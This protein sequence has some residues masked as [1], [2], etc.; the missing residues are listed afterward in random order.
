MT[1]SLQLPLGEPVNVVAAPHSGG[2]EATSAPPAPTQVALPKVGLVLLVGISGSGKST[3]AAQHFKPTQVISSDFCRALV[4]D[5]ES[6]QAATPDAFAVLNYIVGTR[7]KRGLLTVV[8]A[9]NV[10]KS[11]RAELVKL[12]KDHDVLVDAIV[13][14]VPPNLA[15][16]RGRNRAVIA[17]QYEDLKRSLSQL[18]KEGFRRVHVLSAGEIANAQ[19]SYQKSWN[20]LTE[21][22]GPFDIIGDVHGCLTELVELLS[23][24]GY[25]IELSDNSPVNARHPEGR[26]AIFVGDLVDRG[27]DTP[28]VL[29]LVMGMVQAGNALC[30]AGNH[31]AKLVRALK[32]A[33]VQKTHGIEQSLAQFENETPEFRKQAL[34]FMDK[35]IAYYVL[36]DGQLIVAHAGLKEAYHGRSSN[37]VRAFALYG[38]TTG[39]SDEYGLPVRLPWAQEYRG[40][41]LVVYGHTPTLDPEW[42]N[43]TICVD[44]GCVFGGKLTAMRYPERQLVSV[45]AQA[46]Y[47]QPA[48]PLTPQ[49]SERI[50]SVLQITDVAGTRWLETQLA[51]RV[52]VPEENAVAA[53]EVMS[54][55]AV[56]PRWLIYLPPT[57]SPAP[58]VS[59]KDLD[60]AGFL[61]WPEQ[62]FNEYAAAGVQEVVC[63][64]KHMGSRAVAVIARDAQ[65]AERRFGI[66]PDG[67]GQCALGAVYTRTGRA[68]FP[69]ELG[70]AL[71]RR[72]HTAIEPLFAALNTDWLALDC[73]L[74]P[75][76]AKAL[77]L[78]KEQYAAVGAAAN[79]VFPPATALLTQAAARGLDV[80]DLAGRVQHRAAD[81]AAYRDAYAAYVRPTDGLDG[82]TLA[83]FQILAGEGEVYALTR[84]HRWH[85]QQIALLNDPFIM[86][87]RHMFVDLTDDAQRAAGTSWWLDLTAYGGEGM[88][89]KPVLPLP[90]LT[91][92]STKHQI[93]P[94]L[95][96]RG[97]EYLRIIY[98]PDY[99]DNLA[100]LRNR[101]LGRKK[102]LAWR[103]FGLGME[104][105]TKFVA[106]DPLWQIHQLVF[107]I[108]ALE[109]EA[110]DPRL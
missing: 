77:G 51:G 43:N 11:A 24:L 4:S 8:D 78:I 31:E 39:E 36:D 93:Q 35:L 104:S 10:Q 37:R 28:G 94:G 26:T 88:V 90:Q 20:D 42:I 29:R 56:D 52:K 72:V 82:I 76:S 64:E 98:G 22:N 23:K 100:N 41:A 101:Q 67:T 84:S 58:A 14:D 74:L 47:Y 75:W 16:A 99:L 49:V 25:V 59:G 91:S 18:R 46:Q 1:D 38:D 80:A 12:A 69:G 89:V 17:R 107:A 96:V 50:P 30:V 66:V 103:E 32:G 40:K 95:K 71:V 73:E 85:L 3:F 15:I 61:E 62:A 65:A 48:K 57:M 44:T 92:N 110:I 109:S 87:T 19:I 68:F 34:D 86:Q 54:R 83:P 53:L 6:D 105:L 5:D 63:E 2:F 9:T 81:A 97:R 60:T 102:N 27:P 13:L 45:A 55:F 7:L 108:L 70:E 21:L 33:K 106:A 79:A